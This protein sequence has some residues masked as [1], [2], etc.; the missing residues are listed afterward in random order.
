MMPSS[1]VLTHRKDDVAIVELNRPER[2]NA[3]SQDLINE[4]I[5]V[6]SRMD[7]DSTVRAIV[8]TSSGSESFCGRSSQT[9]QE[10]AYTDLHSQLEQISMSWPTS[11]QLRLSDVGG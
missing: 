8:L 4:L 11:P 9:Q 5:D 2:R 1:L 7:Q 3:L 6:L 10:R